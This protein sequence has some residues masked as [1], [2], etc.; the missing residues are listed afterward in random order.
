MAWWRM[1]LTP[2]AR[3]ESKVNIHGREG[4]HF[5]IPTIAPLHDGTPIHALTSSQGV[6]MRG[7]EHFWNV[8]SLVK[9]P[10]FTVGPTT[11]SFNL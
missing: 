3:V 1:E 6:S 7:G 11:I 9:F 10:I 4:K 8:H 2:L 5:V